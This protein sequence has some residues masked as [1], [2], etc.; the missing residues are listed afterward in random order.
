MVQDRTRRV[1]TGVVSPMR[2]QWPSAIAV[3]LTILASAC[4]APPPPSALTLAATLPVSTA[5]S[6]AP[7]WRRGYERAIA[8]VNRANGLLLS[9]TGERVRVALRIIDDNGELAR[10]ELAAEELLASGVDALLATPGALRMAAQAAAAGRHGRPYFVPAPAGPDL[11]TSDRPW[12]FVAPEDGANDEERAYLTARAALD[13]LAR[14]HTLD[15]EAV[16]RAF[17][18][19]DASKHQSI[20]AVH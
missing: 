10:A 1:R 18:G 13:T 14:A 2:T 3:V 9:A 19:G 5:D 20:A 11:T 7:A 15:A 8:E 4:D 17:G 12:V 6:T 16:R